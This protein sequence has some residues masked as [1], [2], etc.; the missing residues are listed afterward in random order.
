[1]DWNE[2]LKPLHFEQLPDPIAHYLLVL[3]NLFEI[4]FSRQRV[5]LNRSRVD[6]QVGYLMTRHPIYVRRTTETA[7]LSLN[8]LETQLLYLAGHQLT[9]GE[10][11]ARLG[12]TEEQL[13]PVLRRLVE[14]DLALV[15]P[16][17]K[18]AARLQH[19]LAT[20]QFQPGLAE[21]TLV[22]LWQRAL[23]YYG[24]HPLLY[25]E[26]GE[27]TFSYTEAFEVVEMIANRLLEG[28]LQKVDRVLLLGHAQAEM[29]LTLWACTQIGAVA[30]PLSAHI[31]KAHLQQVLKT[32]GPALMFADP[33]L[34]QSAVAL[35]A[36]TP[37]LCFDELE[38]PA[39][40][41]GQSFSDWL[42]EVETEGRDHWPKI[43]SEDPAVLLFTSGST[44]RPKGVPLS[45]GHLYRSARLITETFEWE[46]TDRFLAISDLD[47]MSGLRNACFAPLEVGATLLLPKPERQQNAFALAE[48]IGEQAA[49]IIG[50]TPPLFRHFL[51]FAGRVKQQL[52]RL[53]L[54]LCTG[55]PLH[56][57][58][59]QGFK[60]TFGLD[61]FNYYGLTETT[62]ICTAE[63]PGKLSDIPFSIGWPV[64]GILQVVDEG[65]KLCPAGETGQLRLYS[66]NNMT[67]Y[68]QDEAQSQA[69]LRNGWFYTGDLAKFNPDGSISLV[70]RQREIIKV[71]NGDVVYPSEIEE[72]LL[73]FEGIGQAAVCKYMVQDAEQMIA[74][75]TSKERQ[76]VDLKPIKE[77]L[78]QQ[79]GPHKVPH[80]F[81]QVEDF[82]LLSNGK[83]NKN[84]LTETL[85]EDH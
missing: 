5:S 14:H 44:S 65:D 67:G 24:D 68:W 73:Q 27:S 58:L 35:A 22:Q 6:G 80:R 55:S 39:P 1:E 79:L 30:V 57:E 77:A 78:T 43:A 4:D 17:S 54:C 13:L 33:A 69:V 46:A 26:S 19:F 45:Q 41:L 9:I 56:P 28:G 63:G 81:Q 16:L 74:F 53:R 66:L 75:F 84:A 76:P 51:N 12:Q 18:S 70:G 3:N 38:D 25:S 83:V 20:Q 50:G 32:A 34:A 10:M 64:E 2:P 52:D 23:E 59:R 72:A 40:G 61:L 15:L 31:G 37:V 62:G 49:T 48:I 7:S 85:D 8:T 36:A 42:E 82:P 29:V 47:S 21:Q 71:A 60:K 11:A